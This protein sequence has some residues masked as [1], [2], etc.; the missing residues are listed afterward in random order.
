MLPVIRGESR[1][2]QADLIYTLELVAL[3]LLLPIFNMAG[4]VYLVSALALGLWLIHTAWK[5][6]KN[7]G[8]KVAWKMYRYSS[9]YLMFLMI[10]MVI[11]VK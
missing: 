2:A 4:T 6:Y 7:Q 11:D 5:V 9:M 8:N 3:T 10:A 1:N